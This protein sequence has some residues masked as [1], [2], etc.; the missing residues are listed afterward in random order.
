M[1]QASHD[2]DEYRTA[3]RT[4]LSAN[5]P[6]VLA[7]HA[8]TP[9]VQFARRVQRL[10]FGAGYA[11]FV[12]PREYGG[13]GLTRLHE[14]VFEEE[15]G[16]YGNRLTERLGVSVGIIGETLNQFGTDEQKHAYLPRILSG[17]LIFV[18]LLSEPSGG[19]DLAA[20][21]MRAEPDG[22]SYVLNGQKIWST[23]ALDADYALCPARTN[24]DVSKHAGIS[25]FIVDL[26][27]DGVEVRPI[28]QIDGD[29]EF[30][31]EFF[32]D[33]RVPA[34]NLVGA[35][36]D[37]WSVV[38]GLLAIEHQWA[39][40]RRSGRRAPVDVAPLAQLAAEHATA[41]ADADTTRLIVDLYVQAKVH[42]AL[43][44]RVAGR[45]AAGTAA[46]GQGGLLKLSSDALVQRRAEVGLYVAGPDG[47][48]WRPD[49]AGGSGWA[50]E[51]LSSRS[52]SI[53]GGSDEVQRN[54]VGERVLGL[55][56]D[57]AVEPVAFRDEPHN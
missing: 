6:P 57:R 11:G 3:A 54:N 15:L 12:I 1:S 44:G 41:T 38:R 35:A 55:P 28:R 18:Q 5:L 22:D 53:A 52:A 31:E 25:M 33:V 19:S 51:F 10:L 27:A 42:D 29:S 39:G 50:H 43:T 9:P 37:G 48:A 46:A 16:R 20:L 8:T 30:C 36:G 23:G 13:A 34:A 47:V 14:R 49:A 17:E 56:R 21:R 40:R 4:W 26:H 24:W 45:I 7:E 2:L 32:T